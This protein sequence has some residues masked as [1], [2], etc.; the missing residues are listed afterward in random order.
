MVLLTM[1]FL[2]SGSV[3]TSLAICSL[4]DG[5]VSNRIWKKYAVLISEFGPRDT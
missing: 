5:Q 4:V 3:L 1:N 2:V